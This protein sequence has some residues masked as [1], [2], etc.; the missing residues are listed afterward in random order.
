MQTLT[1]ADIERHRCS[2]SSWNE[3]DDDCP[4][5]P[6]VSPEDSAQRKRWARQSEMYA[7]H[8]LSL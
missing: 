3:T 8:T 6:E 2:V 1:P 5:P 7:V 4:R